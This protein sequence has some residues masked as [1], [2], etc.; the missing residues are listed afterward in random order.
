MSSD[1]SRWETRASHSVKRVAGQLIVLWVTAITPMQTMA[2]EGVLVFRGQVVNS[3]CDMKQSRRQGASGTMF[4]VQVQ[5]GVFL[6][7]NTQDNACT[8]EAV[9]FTTHFQALPH[10]KDAPRTLSTSPAGVVTI[11]YQ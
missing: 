1:T 2:Q 10:A 5:P 7:V 9:P 11:T 3:T 4:Q 8:G 6:D